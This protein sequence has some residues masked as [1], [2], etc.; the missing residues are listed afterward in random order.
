MAITLDGRAERETVLLWEPATLPLPVEQRMSGSFLQIRWD[1]TRE[2][3]PGAFKIS[4]HEVSLEMGL[5][6]KVRMGRT[7]KMSETEEYSNPKVR[8]HD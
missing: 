7:T 8:M 6:T 3:W 1:H 5:Q 2:S 4:T